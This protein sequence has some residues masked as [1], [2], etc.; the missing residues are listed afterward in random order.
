MPQM[1][2]AVRYSDKAGSQLGQS[3][4]GG[5]LEDKGCK[6]MVLRSIWGIFKKKEGC[7]AF[8]GVQKY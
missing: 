6:N 5:K 2:I 8:F 1:H 4:Y 3:N 7:S